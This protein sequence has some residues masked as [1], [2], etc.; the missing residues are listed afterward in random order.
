MDDKP[1]LEGIELELFNGNSKWLN[2]R[3]NLVRIF[4]MRLL[5]NDFVKDL[6]SE[7]H[8][9]TRLAILSYRRQVH[10][11]FQASDYVAHDIHTLVEGI[12]EFFS[13]REY[14]PVNGNPMC[15]V[16]DQVVNVQFR[17]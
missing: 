17:W 11:S 7:T 2:D 8:R 16:E 15:S 6:L 1:E 10:F 9:Q 12:N 13:N 5:N 3:H 4:Y 14:K